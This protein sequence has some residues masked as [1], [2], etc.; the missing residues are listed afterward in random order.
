MQERIHEALRRNAVDE[1][2]ALAQDWVARAP[3]DAGA[4]RSLS[5]ALAQS[6]D[7]A[8]ALVAL[9]QAILLAPEDAG[10][11]FER[12]A[13]LLRSRDSAAARV[14]LDESLGLD[15]NHLPS[16]L[17]QAHLALGRDD[18]ADAERLSRTAARI[19]ADNPQL[20]ALNALLALR[21][22]EADHAIAL[23]S[24]ASVQLRDDPQL[25]SVLGF[26]YLA[27]R[28]WAFAEQ[29]FRR[30]VDLLP[31]ARALQPLLAQLAAT[32]GRPDEA[33]DLLAPLIA[34]PAT[35]THALRRSAALFALQAGR[36]DQALAQ[37][38]DSLGRQPDDRVVLGALLALWRE[39]D[40]RD[41]A[42]ATL[43]AALATAPT[44]GDLW[45]ARLALE[46]PGTAEGNQVLQR[47]L[48]A[49]PEHIPALE[50]AMFDRDR[51]G[52]LATVAEFARRLTALQPGHA[53]AEQFL[54]EAQL[55][56]D[57]DAA[58]ERARAAIAAQTT[59]ESRIAMRSWLGRLL[60]RAGRTADALAHWRAL[61]SE[62]NARR[63]PLPPFTDAAIE[64]PPLATASVDAPNPMLV[65]GL[66]GSGIERVVETLAA[67][68]G[69]VLHDRFSAQAPADPL[70]S[71]QIG[72]ELREG[73][74]DPMQVVAQWRTHLRPRGIAD[75]N[76]VDWLPWWDN[77]LLLALRPYLPEGLLLVAVR[78]PRD[79]LLDWLASG[80][81]VPLAVESPQAAAE[82]LAQ[83]LEQVADLH[84]RDLYP[85][86]LLRLDSAI[87]S[88]PAL[89]TV[90][91][92]A[93][94]I[95]LPPLSTAARRMPAGRWRA[96]ADVL[97]GP[98]E[99]LA[100]VAAR[101]GYPDA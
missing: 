73:T 50:T 25:L 52:D 54:V 23:A 40:D 63:L 82:W 37:L 76:V 87:D 56:D 98:F 71:P 81:P 2:L 30:V 43:E 22:G 93:L 18:L 4:H 92:Q 27:K 45:G 7:P 26:G 34:D 13:L 78:D 36:H 49:M 67:A 10:L 57:P 15:P 17:A 66:P 59:D 75:G 33:A 85:H 5:L 48:A 47:W 28:H 84:E 83:G 62:F 35:A 65:W 60:D 100:P 21:R 58:L 68:G 1:A 3:E 20:V 99:R 6:G 86:R 79:M 61:H 8:A 70:R 77:A 31:Q 90:I 19:D 74:I 41:G 95:Q 29:S 12:A 39:R 24:A 69:P 80:A 46:T 14:A 101:L 9:D 97:A 53:V 96:Y 91:G 11:H 94:G 72:W 16:Y 51:A 64:W 42:M 89:A 44:V 38:R 55:A 32:Q 88:P